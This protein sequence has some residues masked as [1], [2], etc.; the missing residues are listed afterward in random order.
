MLAGWLFADLFLVLFLVVLSAQP[1]SSLTKHPALHKQTTE[2]HHAKQSHPA[3]SPTVKLVPV[4][5]ENR[6]TNFCIPQTNGQSLLTNFDSQLKAH[7]GEGRKAGFI[8]VFATGTDPGAAV[9]EAS[10]AIAAIRKKD[11]DRAAFVGAFSQGLWGGESNGCG[12]D[13]LHFQ[14]IFYI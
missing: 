13:N 3:R 9:E 10:A 6:I 4:G 8:Q 11:T 2:A 5:L 7:G 1:S 14:I 12:S